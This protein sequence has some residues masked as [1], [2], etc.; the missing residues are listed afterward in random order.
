MTAA[1]AAMA[2]RGRRKKASK[3]NRGPQVAAMTARWQISRFSALLLN[4][5]SRR[6][7]QLIAPKIRKIYAEIR[8]FKQDDFQEQ[9]IPL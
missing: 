2:S 3:I 4:S 1:A 7:R 6:V 9:F 5:V 8:T